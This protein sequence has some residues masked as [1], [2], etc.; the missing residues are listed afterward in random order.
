MS[1]IIAVPVFNAQ[2]YLQHAIRSIKNQTYKEWQCVVLDDGSSDNS[3]EMVEKLADKRFKI[4]SDGLN[5]GLAFRLNE[6]IEMVD[7][8][9]LVRMD[10]DDIMHPLRIERQLGYMRNNRSV[11]A[12]GSSAYLIDIDNN[13]YGVRRAKTLLKKNDFLSTSPMIHPSVMGK[14]AWFKNN[15]YDLKSPRIEDYELWLRTFER[16]VF[17]NLTEP[18]L[19]YRELGLPYKEKYHYTSVGKRRVLFNYGLRSGDIVGA[20][21]YI[22]ESGLK[23]AVFRVASQIGSQEDLMRKRAEKVPPGELLTAVAD[24]KQALHDG[25]GDG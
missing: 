12:V 7:C 19:Y 2:K 5:K 16:S 4:I 20:G 8:D 3:L 22:L 13:I 9:Y 15:K 6:V 24:L 18:L 14:A 17:V 21:R 25:G 1:V 11:D 23:Q 10:A